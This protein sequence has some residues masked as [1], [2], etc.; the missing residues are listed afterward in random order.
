MPG[1]VL[2][3]FNLLINY[4]VNKDYFHGESKCNPDDL[5]GNHTTPDQGKSHYK[6]ICD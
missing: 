1:L 5:A 2:F 6:K 4:T 3:S